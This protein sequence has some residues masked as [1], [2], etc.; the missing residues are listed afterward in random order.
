MAEMKFGVLQFPGS[1]DDRDAA[2]RLPPGR[3]G[4]PRV[5]RGHRPRGRRRRRRA[6]AGSRTVTTCG[7]ARSPGSRRRWRRWPRH[8]AAGGAGARRSAT[9]SR[10]CARRGCCRG[11][12]CRTT[13]FASSAGRWSV[14]V[15]NAETPFTGECRSGERLS[16]PVKHESGRYFAPARSARRDRGSRRR[17]ASLRA[18]PEPE[19][20]ACGTSPGVVN[21][22]GTS[23]G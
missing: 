14:V 9:A 10:C 12:C 4:A 15:E 2:A 3:G 18:G 13:R 16:I 17:R 20:L 7:R 5:A 23:W 6:R 19:R 8:A 22:R 11:R 21:E 1:C